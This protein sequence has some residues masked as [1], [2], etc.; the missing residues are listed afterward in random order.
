MK[1]MVPGWRYRMPVGKVSDFGQ[2]STD[3]P[4]KNVE[5]FVSTGE[6]MSLELHE[7]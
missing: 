4:M 6:K 5:P 3:G 2:R 7:G 1:K